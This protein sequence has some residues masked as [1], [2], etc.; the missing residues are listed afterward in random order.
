MNYLVAQY[1]MCANS[2]QTASLSLVFRVQGSYTWLRTTLQYGFHSYTV[3]LVVGNHFQIKIV[4]ALLTIMLSSHHQLMTY[5]INHPAITPRKYMDSSN[6]KCVGNLRSSKSILHLTPFTLRRSRCPAAPNYCQ[7][8]HQVTANGNQSLSLVQTY[9]Y[10][11]LLETKR[12]EKWYWM[13]K[14]E[15]LF[16]WMKILLVSL[17]MVNT[18]VTLV[19]AFNLICVRRLVLSAALSEFYITVNEWSLRVNVWVHEC[20]RVCSTCMLLCHS[21]RDVLLSISIDNSL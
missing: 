7:P 17:Q 1:C 15:N 4:M 13:W 9:W 10:W 6:G 12:L 11:S 21:V 14:Q 19:Y 3:A 20:V 18:L 8:T 16:M 5:K 2:F